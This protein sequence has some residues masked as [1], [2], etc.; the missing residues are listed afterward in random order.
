MSA[1]VYLCIAI[2]F[3]ISATLC[4]KLSDGFANMAYGSLSL[5][6][7]GLCFAFMAP[8]IKIIPVG[9]AYAVWSGLGL[10]GIA[11]LSLLFFEQ[12]LSPTQIGFMGLILIGAVGLNI[13]TKV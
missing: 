5:V 13:T 2:A 11:V 12:K 8:A 3:E 6:L 4:L 1:W 10:V 7:Y 9:V